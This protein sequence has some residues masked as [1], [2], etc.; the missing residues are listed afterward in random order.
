MWNMGKMHM[1]TGADRASSDAMI[2][3]TSLIHEDSRRMIAPV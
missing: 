1:K 3:L 2:G